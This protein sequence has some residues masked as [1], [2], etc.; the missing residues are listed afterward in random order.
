M[1][2]LLVRSSSS[3]LGESL[4]KFKALSANPL[5]L[6]K[7]KESQSYPEKNVRVFP[8]YSFIFSEIE[9]KKSSKL[10]NKTKFAEEYIPCKKQYLQSYRQLYM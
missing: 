1:A 4:K 7:A 8:L 9:V 6:S 2:I 5:N 10:T 3:V